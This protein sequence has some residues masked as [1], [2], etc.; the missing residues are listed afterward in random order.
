M[1]DVISFFELVGQDAGLHDAAVSELE[2]ALAQTDISAELKSAILE[3]DHRLITQLL[4]GR[5]NVCC[6]LF[7]GREDEEEDDTDDEGP[8]KDDEEISSYTSIQ[9]AA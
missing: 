1:S 7:P 2:I 9:H 3:R 4:G 6:G 8:E 5:S